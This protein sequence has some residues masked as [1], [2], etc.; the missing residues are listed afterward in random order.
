MLRVT[1]RNSD[2]SVSAATALVFLACILGAVFDGHLNSFCPFSSGINFNIFFML[3]VSRTP[4]VFSFCSLFLRGV[5]FN[6]DLFAASLV[7]WRFDIEAV[8]LEHGLEFLRLLLLFFGAL[9]DSTETIWDTK[10]NADCLCGV[11]GIKKGLGQGDWMD[12]DADE[13]ERIE[14]ILISFALDDVCASHIIGLK[15]I[16]SVRMLSGDEQ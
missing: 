9:A 1:R 3:R 13:V 10:E 8:A 4:A 7:F 16:S 5:A 2:S 14:G 15:Y 6:R 12:V 11:I